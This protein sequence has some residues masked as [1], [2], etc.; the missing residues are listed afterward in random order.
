[1]ENTPVHPKL[2]HRDFWLL[3]I[4]SFLI[5]MPM[6][7]MIPLLPEWLSQRTALSS[8]EIGLVMLAYG[9]GLF[10]FGPVC[11]HLIQRY[12]RNV[13]FIAAA[14]GV[15]LLIMSFFAMERSADGWLLS[16]GALFGLRFALG[17]LFGLA[18][19]ILLSTLIID[20]TESSYRD[21][22]N[23][24]VVWFGR[25]PLVLGPLVAIQLN[26]YLSIDIIVIIM[27]AMALL[28]AVLVRLISIPF[29]APDDTK[30]IFSTDRFLLKES[31]WCFLNLLLFTSFFGMMLFWQINTT[32]FGMLMVGFYFALRFGK[33]LLSDSDRRQ[34]M[35]LAF[36][37]SVLSMLT[38]YI[39]DSEWVW[40][41]VTPVLLGFVAGIVC[42]R[43]M[44]LFLNISHHCQRGTSQSSFFLSWEFGIT[45]GVF[46]IF[47]SDDPE[48]MLL[49]GLSL[50]IA[51]FAMYF[52]FTHNWH[53]RHKIR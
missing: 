47:I 32:M 14:V 24:A 42:N 11:N 35:Y 43:F 1:M 34:D 21:D 44:Y 29:K 20:V 40:H 39:F 19:M 51:A 31:G 23:Y 48:H 36:A 2:W 30:S 52:L 45:I 38:P 4:A 15:V 33:T 9:L 22:A 12:R 6:Y 25:F 49:T 3:A 13:M 46:L 17:A 10:V 18:E 27:S 8:S 53:V 5:T 26:R 50:L 28:S 37:L 41:Y 16:F 7:M